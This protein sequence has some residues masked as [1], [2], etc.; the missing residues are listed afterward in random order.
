MNDLRND[1]CKTDV[2]PCAVVSAVGLVVDVVFPVVPAVVP[3][4]VPVAVD[5]V[6]VGSGAVSVA[7]AIPG[8]P[9]PPVPPG[10][11]APGVV[12]VRLGA[13][14]KSHLLCT[15]SLPSWITK[16]KQDC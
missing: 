4:V 2:G 13:M 6:V 11:V 14:I 7:P 16:R 12:V 5:V 1:R 10:P 8:M 3:A 15:F 9:E